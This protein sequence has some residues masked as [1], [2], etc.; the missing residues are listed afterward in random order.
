MK[1]SVSGNP[2]P[3][4]NLKFKFVFSNQ[5]FNIFDIQNP[6]QLEL[7][8]GMLHRSFCRGFVNKIAGGQSLLHPIS[9]TVRNTGFS[10]K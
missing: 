5:K 10:G 2:M 7:R 9:D 8:A 4:T 6:P 1:A 3:K